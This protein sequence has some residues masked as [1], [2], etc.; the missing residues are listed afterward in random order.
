MK[1]HK[2]DTDIIIAYLGV[3]TGFIVKILPILQFIAL[4]LTIFVTILRIK[5]ERNRDKQNIQK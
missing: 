3:L 1:I 4:V 2:S 5:R